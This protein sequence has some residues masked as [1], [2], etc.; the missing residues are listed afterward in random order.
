MKRVSFLAIF[1][2]LSLF[3]LANSG[4]EA[5][6]ISFAEKFAATGVTG[7]TGAYT[8]DRAHSFIG[9]KVKHMGLVEV[10][11]FFRD[12]TGTV[13]YDAKDVTR[14]T[15]EF[16]AKTTSVDTGVAPRDKHLRT[17]DFFDVEKYPELT[18]K[19]TKIEKK[20]KNLLVTGD[21]TIKGV[22]KSVA[23][24]FQIAGWI[25]NDRGI[26]MGIAA[27][28]T[29]NRK[30]YGVNYGKTLPGGIAE[31]SNDV[32]IVLQIE[33]GKAKAPPKAE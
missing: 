26:R 3:I 18:F 8:F 15:V 1:A 27:E 24:P 29:V 21:L 31:L 19:S 10:P 17:T 22:T 28:T 23:I 32:K 9:F 16:T 33:A 5:V 6:N 25:D 14:S 4:A 12:F 7:D 11:G 20:G 13:N 2:F 30:D